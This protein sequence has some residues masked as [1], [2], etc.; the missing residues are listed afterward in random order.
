MASTDPTSP[1]GSGHFNSTP[2]G[3]SLTAL[4]LDSLGAALFAAA[5][6]TRFF[7][8]EALIPGTSP[9]RGRRLSGR[10]PGRHA[11][12]PERYH[13]GSV[14]SLGAQRLLVPGRRA[15]SLETRGRARGNQAVTFELFYEGSPHSQKSIQKRAG[16]FSFRI[17]AISKSGLVAQSHFCGIPTTRPVNFGELSNDPAAGGGGF[18]LTRVENHSAS[19]IILLLAA[20]SCR[21]A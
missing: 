10:D 20:S 17:T 8:I 21:S 11:L 3:R 6:W 16:M 13:R 5:V 12:R 19:K 7:Y 1:A 4:E 9:A 18:D 14:L 15:S 2:S